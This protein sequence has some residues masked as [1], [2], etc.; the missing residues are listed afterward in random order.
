MKAKL[1]RAVQSALGLDRLLHEPVRLALVTVLS[2]ADWVE[3]GFLERT[4]GLSKGN[5]S[6]HLSKLEGGAMIEID[7][8]FRDKRPLTRARLTPD[9]RAAL[10]RYREALAAVLAAPK[11]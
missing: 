10:A 3:F 8:S 2:A 7:K 6:S 1:E 4:C 5:L 11:S 9:G